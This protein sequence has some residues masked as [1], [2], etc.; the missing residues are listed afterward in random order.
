MRLS[1]RKS[2]IHERLPEGSLYSMTSVM[3]AVTET[4]LS[5]LVTTICHSPRLALRGIEKLTEA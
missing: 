2:G 1:D 4:A 5:I 3:G